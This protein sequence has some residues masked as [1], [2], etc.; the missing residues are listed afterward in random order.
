MRIMITVAVAV[1]ALFCDLR[2]SH[3]GETPWCAV[4]GGWDTV[5]EDCSY[6]SLEA[7]RPN[8]IAGLRGFCLQNPRWPGYYATAP[9]Q[10]KIRQKP[11]RQRD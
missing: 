5:I 7:C 6:W 3:A 11:Q 10:R 1:A 9:D 8:V 4:V 2:A